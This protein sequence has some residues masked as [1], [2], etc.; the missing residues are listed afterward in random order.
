MIN[1]QQDAD[2]FIRMNRHFPGSTLIS[3]TFSD[4]STEQ[5]SGRQLNKVYDEALAVYRA[6]NHLDAKGYSRAP[7]KTVQPAHKIEFVAVHPGMAK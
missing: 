4:G 1:L 3:I 5:F 7:K 2:G 6:E